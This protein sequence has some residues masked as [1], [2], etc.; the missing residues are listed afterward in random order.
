MLTQPLGQMAFISECWKSLTS[1]C[2][3][4]I[5]VTRGIIYDI[6]G[7]EVGILICLRSTNC[8]SE[9]R[10][11]ANITSLYVKWVWLHRNPVTWCVTGVTTSTDGCCCNVAP[12]VHS[13]DFQEYIV[14][15]YRVYSL[16][17]GVSRGWLAF[18]KGLLFLRA[19]CL[20][21]HRRYLSRR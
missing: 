11:W 15:N 19:A 17:G 8:D 12:T 7:L 2:S 5:G 4:Y 9:S 13:R 3:G 21:V 16:S 18:I 14:M 10:V 1:C 20:L 6:T